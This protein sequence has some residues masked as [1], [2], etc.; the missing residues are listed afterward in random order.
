[1]ETMGPDF[2]TFLLVWVEA[3]VQ[4]LQGREEGGVKLRLDFFYNHGH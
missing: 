4:S 2:L 3:S 1:M